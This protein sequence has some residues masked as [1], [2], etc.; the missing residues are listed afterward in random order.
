MTYIL[1]PNMSSESKLWMGKIEKWMNEKTIMK[2]FNE[3]NFIPKKIQMVN[4]KNSDGFCD[5]CYIYF[6][7]IYDANEA[8]TKLKGKNIPNS[9]SIFRLNWAKPNSEN[10]DIYVGNLSPEIDNMELYNL[11]KGKYPSVH[12]ASIITTNNNVSKGYGF[13]NFL[14]KEEAEKCIQEMDGYIIYNKA[15]KLKNTRNYNYQNTNDE[16]IQQG[17]IAEFELMGN[18]YEMKLI[19]ILKGHKGPVTNLVYLKDEN[20][21]PLLFSGS[22]DTT[23]IQWKLLYKNGVLGEENKNSKNGKIVGKP[24]KI[25]KEHTEPITSLSLNS[26][27]NRLVSSSLDKKIIIWDIPGLKKKSY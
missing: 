9:N 5:F 25:V 2:L 7:N 22:D 16:K 23:I 15:L 19:G 27:K 4:N 1:I 13:I 17:K 6:D 24:I 3:F 12:H 14:N 8:L 18:Y 26:D 10:I 21:C 20:C 11:F